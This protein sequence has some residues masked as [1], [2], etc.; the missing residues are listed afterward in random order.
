MPI[1]CASK[2]SVQPCTLG[3]SAS[4]SFST[5]GLSLPKLCSPYKDIPT[6]CALNSCLQ[7]KIFGTNVETKFKTVEVLQVKCCMP[8]NAMPIFRG[9]NSTSQPRTLG[10][11]AETNFKTSEWSLRQC[12]KPYSA[13]PTAWALNAVLHSWIFGVSTANSRRTS[14]CSLLKCWRPN[15]AIPSVWALNTS[16]QAL[17]FGT[18]VATSFKISWAFDL[19][20][21]QS[22][23]L[24][25]AFSAY[26]AF[27]RSTIRMGFTWSFN[28]AV[29]KGT[30]RFIF[31]FATLYIRSTSC[32][33]SKEASLLPCCIRISYSFCRLDRE[34][35]SWNVSLIFLEIG[36]AFCSDWEVFSEKASLKFLLCIEFNTR[37]DWTFSGKFSLIFFGIALDLLA[38]HW[39]FFDE[40]TGWQK[41][42][43]WSC[44][45]LR[46]RMT[47]RII[48]KG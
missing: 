41:C 34:F 25:I 18:N 17:T 46:E 3:I 9:L 31:S 5:S 8:Y 20:T 38:K 33:A 16:W 4:T 48:L 22:T 36:L 7:L 28:A 30:L 2:S 26:R 45:L 1:V 37:S 10:A 11:S 6:A 23:F 35:P 12:C 43:K 19:S 47:W 29:V 42:E 21:F 14:S 13:L 24:S 32:F 39:K 27:P 44:L 15:S 40:V